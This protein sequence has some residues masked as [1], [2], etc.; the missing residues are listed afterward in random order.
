MELRSCPKCRREA[1]IACK[2]YG[3]ALRRWQHWEL[4]S[5]LAEEEKLASFD[6]FRCFTESQAQA[7]MT[8]RKYSHAVVQRGFGGI[9]VFGQHGRGKTHLVCSLLTYACQLGLFGHYCSWLELSALLQASFKPTAGQ[10][11]EFET[12][13]HSPLLVLDELPSTPWKGWERRKLEYLFDHRYRHALPT[14]WAANCKP[15]ELD[16]ITPLIS[17]RLSC[18]A[19]VLFVDGPD[20]RKREEYFTVARKPAFERPEPPCVRISYPEYSQVLSE[21]EILGYSRIQ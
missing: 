4:H 1:A 16:G 21:S 9:Y 7:L 20:Y 11:L 3:L 13:L 8:F 18:R 15:D 6:N 5:G 14:V 2:E 10:C 19:A 12:A 17:S